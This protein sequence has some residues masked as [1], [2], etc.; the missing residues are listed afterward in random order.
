MQ[1]STLPRKLFTTSSSTSWC[2]RTHAA[3]VYLCPPL[4]FQDK[5]KEQTGLQQCNEKQEGLSPSPANEVRGSKLE[6]AE[7][8]S[9]RPVCFDSIKMQHCAGK[10]GAGN[11]A[12]VKQCCV[13]LRTFEALTDRCFNPQSKLAAAQDPPSPSKVQPGDS[14]GETYCSVKQGAHFSPVMKGGL[15]ALVF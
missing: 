2:R 12:V 6:S 10:R 11:F 4:C 7:V 8:S 9:N 13:E 1:L 15:F 3:H 5:S 14:T